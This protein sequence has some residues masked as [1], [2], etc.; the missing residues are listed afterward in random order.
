MERRMTVAGW[1]KSSF[2]S[3]NGGNCLEAGNAGAAVAVR[4]TK[5]SGKGPVLAFTREAWTTFM[6]A[7]KN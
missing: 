6:A 3:G 2:S 4:D 7:L 5:Q 1:R